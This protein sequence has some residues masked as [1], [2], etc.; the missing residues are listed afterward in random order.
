MDPIYPIFISTNRQ[1][2]I[3]S[4]YTG[5]SVCYICSSIKIR[6][7][8]DQLINK[9]NEPLI[10]IFHYREIVHMLNETVK[11]ITGRELDKIP[12]TDGKGKFLV[13]SK[14]SAKHNFEPTPEP[15]Q[16]KI[17]HLIKRQVKIQARLRA[18]GE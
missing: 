12:L 10:R 18:I 15:E 5:K 17:S 3:I 13:I 2:W 11:E 8:I 4:L 16:S 9:N 7:V 6:N 1:Q 14:T